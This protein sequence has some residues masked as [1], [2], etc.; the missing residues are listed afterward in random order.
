MSKEKAND[1][2]NAEEAAMLLSERAG[3]TISK[4]YVRDLRHQGRLVEAKK[5]GN[6]YLYYRGAVQSVEIRSYKKRATVV[7]NNSHDTAQTAPTK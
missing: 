6:T 2:L 4:D 5:A 3:R 1:L 7:S